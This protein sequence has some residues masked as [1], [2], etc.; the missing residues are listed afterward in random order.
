MELNN[1]LL[2]LDE[3][4]DYLIVFDDMMLRLS[5]VFPYLQKTLLAK[6][7]PLLYVN[8]TNLYF[9]MMQDCITGMVNFSKGYVNDSSFHARRVLESAAVAIKLY[10]SPNKVKIYSGVQTEIERKKYIETF[11]VFKLVKKNL[12]SSTQRQYER[13]CM[14]VHPSAFAIGG[15]ISI[16]ENLQHSM[17]AFEYQGEQDLAKL[18]MHYMVYTQTV[19]NAVKEFLN[20]FNND[21][22]FDTHEANKQLVE[23]MKLWQKYQRSLFLKYPELFLTKDESPDKESPAQKVD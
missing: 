1:L 6:S 10:R 23:F 15:R 12:S 4:S 9:L 19:F 13:L 22:D 17:A 8:V 11:P 7:D 5:N 18:I 20:S 16:D 21:Q 14:S 2:N 3:M